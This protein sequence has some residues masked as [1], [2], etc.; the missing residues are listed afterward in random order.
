MLEIALGAIDREDLAQL[1]IWRNQGD[2]RWMCREYRLL[3]MENQEDWYQ[4]DCRDRRTA[5]FGIWADCGEPATGLV[6]VCGL[7]NIDFVA[8]H[9][10]ISLY[11]GL[12][13]VR[14]RGI[15]TG[16]LEL[17]AAYGFGELRLHRL[18]AEVYAVNVAG[19]SLFESA[20]YTEE[21][22]MREHSFV[23]GKYCD[24]FMYGLLVEEWSATNRDH[25]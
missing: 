15:A 11:I 20:G 12:R 18:Y 7:T 3:T 19:Q 4:A 9:A 23:Q 21:G 13:S 17:L 5:M 22:V 10:E 24:S 8:G 1:M 2:I 16:V 6:G 14:R 25:S